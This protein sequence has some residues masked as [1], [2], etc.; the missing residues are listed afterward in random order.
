MLWGWLLLSL[1][2]TLLTLTVI[3]RFPRNIP[4]D[5]PNGRSL[6]V[7]MIPRIGGFGML[8]GCS[9]AMSM[10]LTFLEVQSW[11]P[12]GCML[13]CAVLLS[14]L[15]L[16][17][18]FKPLPVLLRLMAQSVAAGVAISFTNI[19][20]LPGVLA[21]FLLVWM[22]NLYN[23][24]DG[25][26][27][28]AG[29]MTLIGFSGYAMTAWSVAPDLAMSSAIIAAAAAGFLVF[30]FPPAKIFMGD[31]GSIPLGFLAG[32]LGFAGWNMGV[33]PAEY[34][35]LIFFPFIADSTLTLISRLLKGEVVWRAHNDHCY[36]RLIRMGWSHGRVLWLYGTLMVAALL[37]ASPEVGFGLDE[38]HG[39]LACFA[40][41]FLCI[42]AWVELKW[43]SFSFG[44]SP[45][46]G[47]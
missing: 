31:V 1:F 29:T 47:A 15:S 44:H 35:L 38:L 2:S 5:I 16:M 43:R 18:D 30:N 25:A 21:V 10:R 11:M 19:A 39:L 14:L 3:Q 27:G 41:V 34:P 8:L 23:F 13:L 24:M 36:Q 17:D 37:T 20:A 26:D 6:H 12:L 32:A 7:V 9:L 4:M 22:T 42:F 40:V 46:S 33:W 28:L 45:P